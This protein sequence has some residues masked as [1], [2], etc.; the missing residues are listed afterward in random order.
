MPSAWRIVRPNA[1]GPETYCRWETGCRGLAWQSQARGPSRPGVEWPYLPGRGDEDRLPSRR[2]QLELAHGHREAYHRNQLVRSAVL[3]PKRRGRGRR[4]KK[5]R[6]AI[7]TRKSS[8]DGLEQEFNS[9][10]AQRDACG[11]YIA[12]QKH[13]GWVLL[14]DAYDD[15]GLSGGSLDR[16]CC[17]SL[18]TEDSLCESMR[19]HGLHEQA[20]SRPLSHDE[21]VQLQRVAAQTGVSADLGR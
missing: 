20:T 3:R 13:E 5:T 1:Q 21:L 10:H 11:A 12:S 9:L 6:C 2:A 14:P 19:L 18:A 17:T 15:G 8:E 16:R 7:Y 4:M